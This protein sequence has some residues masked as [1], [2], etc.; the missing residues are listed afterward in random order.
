L[1]QLERRGLIE[2]W[3][4]RELI[5]GQEW[6][7]AIDEN[8]QA[9]DI[10]LLLISPDFMA[11]D[12][13]YEEEM[14]QAIARHERGE[15]SVIP[16]VVRRTDLEGA[17]FKH[18]QSLP[19]D[20]RPIN[21]WSD[22]DEA[23]LDVARGIRKAI[24][25]LVSERGG[26]EQEIAPSP[27]QDESAE[28]VER[29]RDREITDT[30]TFLFTSM[31]DSTSLWQRY[32]LQ[33]PSVLRRHFEILRSCVEKHRGRVFKTVGDACCAIF[34]DP[35]E[36]LRAALEAQKALLAERWS[37]KVPVRV[38]MALHTG[39]AI[40][41]RDGDYVGPPVNLVTRLLSV[42]RGGQVL[43][44]GVVTELVSDDLPYFEPGAELRN[45]GEQR[46][47]DITRPVRIFQ[48]LASGFHHVEGLES[49]DADEER[50]R[51]ERLLGEGGIAR[52]YLA[53]EM[54]FDRTV[55]LKVLRE[56]YAEDSE[57]IERFGREARSA[58]RLSGHPHIV[59]IYARGRSRDGSYYLAMEYVPGGTLKDLIE[60]EGPLPA[61][62]VVEI[63]LQV[64]HAL[65]FAHE[66]G[67]IHR[68]VKPQNVLLTGSGEAKVAD[69]GIARALE[70]TTMT[71]T[72]SILGTPQYLS[73]E[74]ALGQPANSQSDLYAFGVVLYEMLT[75]ELPFDAETPIGI[76][77]K[78]ISGEL[79]PPREL[80][81]EV[82][83]QL[84]DIT[85]RLLAREPEER[86]PDAGALIEDLQRISTGVAIGDERIFDASAR[87][88]REAE[89][90]SREK[91]RKKKLDRLYAQARRSHQDR[92][93]QAVVDVFAQIHSEDP[94]Y[95][96]PEGLLQSARETLEMNRKEETLRQYRE[97]VEWAWEGSKLYEHDAERLRDLA[98]RLN[99]SPGTAEGIEREVGGDTIEAI[100]EHQEQEQQA[101]TPSRQDYTRLKERRTIV[102]YE[103]PQL[104]YAYDALEPYIDEQTM[105]LHHEKH[106]NT[107]VTNLNA[108]LGKHPEAD[109]GSLEEL[110]ANLD[111]VPQDI[112]TAVRNN[113]GGHSNHS[114]FWQIMKPPR[115]NNQT[116]GELGRA[117]ER[118]FRSFRRFKEIFAAA[119]APGALFGSGWCWL[120]ANPDGS[121]SIE[122]TPNEDS[123]LMEG[124]TP[125]IGL[126][127]W[128][129]AFYL[130]YQNRR[131]QYIENWWNVVN[132]DEAERRYQ[133]A[134]PA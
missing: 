60:R 34:D 69:F 8:L 65:K 101:P 124:K 104:P 116:T 54:E 6:R 66:H 93:W 7:E 133:A 118:K 121:L 106:H 130:K 44:S 90:V 75:G 16:I 114:M 32:R 52:V 117:I 126:D 125:V 11:S 2:W 108:A 9:A 76:A 127:C 87:A 57:V 72:G 56:D 84:N 98:H 63:A 113:A 110:L 88:S 82:P 17:P 71:R 40:E 59:T 77:M 123:P 13:A 41:E 3:H 33:M 49:P 131:P 30:V 14:L 20:L 122:T 4:D 73:P 79:R 5:P 100:L 67:I 102:A 109:P 10:I 29:A 86:Y 58:G 70:A 47:K 81:P 132:W 42:A 97:R 50:Y 85:V 92:E 1:R 36:G 31:E 28:P 83:E 89:R 115:R 105:H 120:I 61:D 96:D 12:F 78:H 46:L 26:R 35:V 43:L 74:Q 51:I 25:R 134:L 23:W 119:A 107:Y 62:E 39:P 55:A 21:A 18:L 27:Q 68:D 37:G 64:A 45:L 19:K 129:H 22:R 24:N 103:L 48:L 38:S 112:R 53:Y 15:A 111:Q 128:D 99:L 91:E 80:N 94:D 95:A